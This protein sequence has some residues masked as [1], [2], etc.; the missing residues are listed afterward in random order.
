MQNESFLIKA[1]LAFPS[2]FQE[3]ENGKYSVQLANLSQAAVTKLEDLGV[4]VKFK[5]DDKYGRGQYVNTTSKFPYKVTI[6]SPEGPVDAK[7][8]EIGYGSVVRARVSTYNWTYG[9]KAGVGVRVETM[10]IDELVEKPVDQI[11]DTEEA[12]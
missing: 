1:V 9:K 6:D 4:D 7:G 10:H 11:D 3:D 12:L 8:M 2:L 5:D